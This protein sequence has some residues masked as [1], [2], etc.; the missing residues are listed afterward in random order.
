MAL[1]FR[2]FGE[3]KREV[4]EGDPATLGPEPKRQPPDGGAGQGENAERREVQRPEQS[5]TE[6]RQLGRLGDGNVPGARARSK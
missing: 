4:D 1:T 6:P 5:D 3:T 2:Q